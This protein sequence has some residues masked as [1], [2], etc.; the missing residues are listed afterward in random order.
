[1]R[2]L[3]ISTHDQR[4]SYRPGEIIS[5]AAGWKLGHP[6]QSV[7]VRLFWRTD[8]KGDL[9][10]GVAEVITFE[11]PLLEEARS[12]SFVAP[13]TPVSFSGTLFSLIWSLEL[14]ALPGTDAARMDLVISP[15]GQPIDLQNLGR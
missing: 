9:D 8:G 6:P 10:T 12:F 15:T 13:A 1:M 14:V 11:H 5:G 4:T 7:E 3:G 2:E